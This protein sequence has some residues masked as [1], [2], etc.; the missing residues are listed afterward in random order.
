MNEARAV[1][2]TQNTGQLLLRYA[3]RPAPAPDVG[4]ELQGIDTPRF[5][6]HAEG[7]QA[8]DLVEVRHGY[9]PFPGRHGVIEDVVE[10]GFVVRFMDRTVRVYSVH[11]LEPV[12]SP[13]KEGILIQGE[14]EYRSDLLCFPV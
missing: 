3:P 13:D 7:C 8:G 12:G 14:H 1:T 10:E 5:I 4:T 2:T 9:R 6:P 11:A